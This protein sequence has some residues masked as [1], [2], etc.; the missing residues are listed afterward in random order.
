[1]DVL[2]TRV[3][4]NFATGRYDKKIPMEKYGDEQVTGMSYNVG[5]LFYLVLFDRLGHDQFMSIL[6]SYYVDNRGGDASLKAMASYYKSKATVKV[7]DIFNDW[8]FTN[9]Y[10]A[11][12]EKAI[13]LEDL[14]AEY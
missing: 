1:M 7:D 10:V 6:K 9:N 2:F 12:F 5:P 14:R 11:K 3:K 8:L 13:G 4:N